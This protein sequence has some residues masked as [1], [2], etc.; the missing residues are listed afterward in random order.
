MVT[1][2]VR[3]EPCRPTASTAGD[4]ADQTA[5]HRKNQLS[6]G[7]VLVG[8]WGGVCIGRF[9]RSWIRLNLMEVRFMRFEDGQNRAR[10]GVR[11]R[12]EGG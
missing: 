4:H 12:A 8:Q 7:G 9:G 5:H 11:E 6:V 10:F 3:R 1:Q 2:A